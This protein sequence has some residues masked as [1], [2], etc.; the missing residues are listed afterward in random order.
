MRSCR[1]T[2]VDLEI[3]P[4]ALKIVNLWIDEGEENS[5]PL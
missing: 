2:E 1:F 5:C 4:E 3:D